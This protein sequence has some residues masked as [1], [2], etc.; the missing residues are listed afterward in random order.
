[1][2][3]AL[4]QGGM[5]LAEPAE[6][7]A[8]SVPTGAV[9]STEGANDEQS[10]E[11]L[12]KKTQNPVSDLI[13]VP[14]QNNFNFGVGPE[15]DVQWILNIQP[16]APVRIAE[17]WTLI[18][19]PI[20]PLIYQPELTSGTGSE[21]GL[22]DIQ[23]QSYL[24]PA[25]PGK[26][27]WGAGAALSFPSATASQLGTGKWSAGPGV[28]VLTMPGHFVLGALANQVWSYAGWGDRNVSQMLIQ[29]IINYN[30]PKGWYLS[31]IPII[32]ANWEA[33]G[34]NRWTVPV[35]GGV[36]K[37]LKVGKLPINTQL[38]AFYNVEKPEVSGADWQLRFQFQFLFPK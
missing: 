35:G 10:S 20:I 3:A 34:S 12:A 29:P 28:V 14:F 19:R 32:T 26:W 22:G 8:G 11:G 13:S 6:G 16:V 36:G 21:F 30:L 31:S 27:I 9:S 18:N 7:T 17:N 4:F 38:Q 33:D 15:N 25:H 5:G 24:S 2:V 23:Y 37:I 1:M